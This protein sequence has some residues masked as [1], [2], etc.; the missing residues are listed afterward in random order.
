MRGIFTCF[1]S[2]SKVFSSAFDSMK[3]GG[4]LELQDSDLNMQRMNGSMDGTALQEW[5]R[6][7]IQGAASMGRNIQVTP[8]FA[9][10][11]RDAGCK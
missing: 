11:V 7:V 10:W 1:D 2:P 8:H 5:S 6:S 4:W 9:D 3:P